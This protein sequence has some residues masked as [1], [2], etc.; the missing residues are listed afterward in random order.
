[1]SSGA[2]DEPQPD[3]DAPSGIERAR[4]VALNM[5]LGGASRDE[6]ERQLRDELDVEDPDEILDEAYGSDGQPMI[7]AEGL[8]KR[9]GESVAVEDV[10][11]EVQPGEIVGLV[12]HEGA[13]KTTTLRMLVGLVTPDGRR[14]DDPRQARSQ[15]SS[16]RC[17]GSGCSSASALHPGRS[18]PRSP[19]HLR[20]AT[21]GLEAAQVGGGA[22]PRRPAARQR[23]PRA[24]AARRHARGGWRSPRRCS[25]TPR[26]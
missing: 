22:A 16:G 14:R 24:R 21:A 12:G 15:R 7:A 26:C 19:A 2:G 18:G 23:A 25:A 13:G 17:S 6:A 4:L 5:A 9:F 10:S 11:F 3:G 20:R 8:T 1:M